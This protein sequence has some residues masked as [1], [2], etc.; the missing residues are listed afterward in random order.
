M[1]LVVA[2][3]DRAV[4]FY[5]RQGLHVSR[6]V[7]GLVYYR[8]RMGVVFPPETRPVALVLM[9]RTVAGQHG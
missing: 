9:R 2:G 8:E 7:D 1:L 3:N 4:R 5:E 6:L